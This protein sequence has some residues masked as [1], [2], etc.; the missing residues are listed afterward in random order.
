MLFATV[1]ALTSAALHATWNLLVKTS[2]S[3]DLTAW[4]QLLVGGALL[5][6]VLLVTGA[7][8][9]DVA[10][11]LVASAL[12]NVAYIR[13]L[14]RAYE[15]GDF[16]VAYPL[17]RG[18]GAVLAALGGAALYGDDLP[19]A[20][21]LGVAIVALGLGSLVDREASRSALLAAGTTGALIATYT[22]IDASGARASDGLAYGI[23]LTFLAGVMLTV[24]G[25][26]QGRGADFV[27]YVRADTWRV[28]VSGLCIT[29]AYSLVMVAVRHAPVGYVAMLRESSVVLGAAAG[30]LLL[31]EPLGHRRLVSSLVITA[32]LVLLVVASA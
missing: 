16:S 9:L 20:A 12:V 7:P 3:R 29:L 11:Q 8:P 27:A 18:S 23:S 32:G 1:L 24:L 17:A 15:H 30:W 13:S 6:P 10:P 19:A 4:G 5:L 2:A 28:V 25:V 22:L 21:W 31:H 26:A 14:V